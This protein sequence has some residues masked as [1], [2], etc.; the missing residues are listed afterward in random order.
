MMRLQLTIQRY[1]LPPVH[2]LWTTGLLR[3][4]H[5]V[6]GTSPTISQLL[7][8]VNDVIPLESGE[9]GLEDYAVEHKTPSNYGSSISESLWTASNL[10]RWPAIKIPPKKRRRILYDEGSNGSGV[11]VVDPGHRVTFN[12]GFDDDANDS[13]QGSHSSEEN[14]TDSADGDIEEALQDELHSLHSELQE[15]SNNIA[16]FDGG[17]KMKLGFES[18][19]DSATP[20]TRSMRQR[21]KGLG[22]EDTLLLVDEYGRPYPKEYDNPLLDYFYDDHPKTGKLSD[23][24]NNMTKVPGGTVTRNKIYQD[25]DSHSKTPSRSSSASTKNVR[26]EEPEVPT[27]ATI[28]EVDI[29]DDSEDE[30]FEPDEDTDTS[31]DESD[32]ENATPRLD[33]SQSE[34]V[35]LRI[36]RSLDDAAQL[37]DQS[38]DDDSSSTSSSDSGSDYEETSSS[39]IS[40]SSSGGSEPEDSDMA[41]SILRGNPTTFRTSSSTS[42]SVGHSSNQYSEG[43]E[44]SW[45]SEADDNHTLT[46][47]TEV[48]RPDINEPLQVSTSIKSFVRPGYGTRATK[49][50][51]QRR[52]ARRNFMRLEKA[53]MLSP[54][55]TAAKSRCLNANNEYLQE[56][57]ENSSGHH[58]LQLNEDKNSLVRTQSF[59]DPVV[60]SE[61]ALDLQRQQADRSLFLQQGQKEHFSNSKPI[62]DQNTNKALDM[63]PLKRAMENSAVQSAP[64]IQAPAYPS[65]QTGSTKPSNT[66][67]LPVGVNLDSGSLTA[68]NSPIPQAPTQNL[69]PR[70]KLDLA[71]SRRLVFGA[72]GHK[73][74]KTKDD[75]LNLR[76]KLSGEVKI[77][78]KSPVEDKSS[79]NVD[80]S[81][82]HCK[83]WENKIDLSAVECCHEGLVLSKPPFPFVQ[84]WDP[85]QQSTNP[86]DEQRINKKRKRQKAHYGESFKP[87]DPT[88]S[89]QRTSPSNGVNAGFQGPRLHYRFDQPQAAMED[90]SEE[91]QKAA[92]DQLMRETNETT[93]GTSSTVDE[94]LSKLGCTPAMRKDELKKYPS[95]NLN[96]CVANAIIAFKQLDMSRETNWQ[97]KISQYRF[98]LITDVL[99]NN[100]IVMKLASSDRPQGEKDYDETTGERLYSKFEMPGYEE[101]EQ[102]PDL[103]ELNYADLIEPLLVRSSNSEEDK[104]LDHRSRESTDHVPHGVETGLI[105]GETHQISSGEQ[106]LQARNESFSESHRDAEA[107]AQARREICDIIR[108]AG[109]RSSIQSNSTVDHKPEQNLLRDKKSAD[110]FDLNQDRSSKPPLSPSFGGFGS[111]PPRGAPFEVEDLITYPA[112][113]RN[114]SPGVVEEGIFDS[115][116]AEA[117]PESSSQTDMS[118]IRQIHEDFENQFRTHEQHPPSGPL[119]EPSDIHPGGPEPAN[120]QE[121]GNVK[122]RDTFQGLPS[123]KMI[124]ET[125]GVV[126]PSSQL[127][128]FISDLRATSD[129]D[130]ECP[131]LERVFSQ[132]RSSFG[133]QPSDPELVKSE[134]QS[135]NEAEEGHSIQDLP[136]W[137]SSQYTNISQLSQEPPKARSSRPKN[138]KPA[139]AKAGARKEMKPEKQG[140]ASTPSQDYIGTQIV[141]LTLSSDPAVDMEMLEDETVRKFALL[142]L[143]TKQHNPS[144]PSLLYSRKQSAEGARLGPEDECLGTRGRDINDLKASLPW[145]GSSRRH[146]AGKMQGSCYES[147]ALQANVCT[148]CRAA[149]ASGHG[150]LDGLR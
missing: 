40:S 56:E 12:A 110:S 45:S 48:K 130:D 17:L 63:S 19:Q 53:G 68:N 142:N 146:E 24:Q 30:N 121:L 46:S 88:I 141:D 41:R 76:A 102:E 66:A 60:S 113:Q 57:N 100:T 103:L 69:K 148:C 147:I 14:D 105:N 2:I 26:F 104:D 109:W 51:N 16:I 5:A 32:K 28:M 82:K 77:P 128:S 50:R 37:R 122:A 44:E 96:A 134:P 84:R 81:A 91:N 80:Q 8:Q 52:S 135:S 126:V 108:D 124:P 89:E 87:V 73:A 93:C 22:L 65:G 25:V 115:C 132:V 107:S 59:L 64:A 62:D 49:M 78:K 143:G 72:L 116:Q 98:A 36:W 133:T 129:D 1:A 112:I 75:E 144:Q 61:A 39:G 18:G 106:P 43:V 85:Q 137:K 114:I 101:S 79:N 118:A 74:P 4:H 94:L 55:A 21:N 97:P 145:V 11:L 15:D 120:H 99:A 123:P 27:P 3:P 35:N 95:L 9:W 92:D 117:I 23:S 58:G 139:Q 42:S 31:I 47:A 125:Q 70:S 13:F 140:T 29:T 67:V 33:K 34:K 10:G 54:N 38:M 119:N 6:A 131:P 136:A 20:T 149:L 111:S 138:L 90:T 127:D 86:N 71:S 150:L 7:E 83:T